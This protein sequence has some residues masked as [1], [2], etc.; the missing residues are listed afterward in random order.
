MFRKF[1]TLSACALVLAIGCSSTNGGRTTK[2][3]SSAFA[4]AMVS[5]EFPSAE[6]YRKILA[7]SGSWEL[8]IRAASETLFAKTWSLPDTM[9]ANFDPGPIPAV[10]TTIFSLSVRTASD[11]LIY[12]GSDTLEVEA[13]ASVQ[14]NL[15]VRSLFGGV[16]AAL[17]I[18]PQL[19]TSID[20]INLVAEW[21]DEAPIVRR[22]T[23]VGDSAFGEIQGIPA[24]SDRIIS[25]Y[26]LDS[27]DR[28]LY[29]GKDTVDLVSGQTT[30]LS[31]KLSLVGGTTL[32]TAALDASGSV[33][34][35]GI[36]PQQDT[37][38]SDS[39][40]VLVPAGV[41]IMGPD[42]AESSVA[43][44]TFRIDPMEVTNRAF[45]AFLNADTAFAKYFYDSMAIAKTGSAFEP[46]TGFEEHPVTYASWSAAN[47]FCTWKGKR[48]P[49][50]KEWEKAARGEDGR[51]YPWGE[52]AP[53][54]TMLNWSSKFG[55]TTSAGRFEAGKSPYGIYDMSGNVWEWCSD[56]ISSNRV[57]KGGGWNSNTSS[58]HPSY[59]SKISPSSKEKALGFRCAK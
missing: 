47:A 46:K 8:L 16:L 56:A 25:L 55:G 12:Q 29:S 2:P 49:L 59:Q 40:M 4:S 57:R 22:L 23:I 14:V 13:G 17:T 26:V 19:Q 36:F 3:D 5:V 38:A 48:L 10:G 53:D 33:V 34:V 1:A 32:V 51:T 28:L 58:V 20:H 43:V 18:P 45:S 15:R 6:E 41:F 42:T 39:E 9:P 7:S 27:G 11:S 37:I 24:G 54:T 30:A 44:D 21:D 35:R 52:A 50:E 31:L